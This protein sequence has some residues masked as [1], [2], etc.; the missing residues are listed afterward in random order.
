[1]TDFSRRW[2]LSE[3]RR[4]DQSWG[5]GRKEGPGEEERS[6]FTLL[7]QPGGK[8]RVS[9]RAK[10]LHYGRC[11]PLSPSHLP[12]TVLGDGHPAAGAGGGGGQGA[13]EEG[14]VCGLEGP[15]CEARRAGRGRPATGGPLH[16][17]S[18]PVPCRSPVRNTQVKPHL[19]VP[20]SAVLAVRCAG[21]AVL[22]WAG[23][24]ANV[25]SGPSVPPNLLPGLGTA[26]SKQQ[27]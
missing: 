18:S 16:Q 6:P 5:W 14:P 24:V 20:Q 13:R 23:A 17:A 11:I 12:P 27:R 4:Q 21:T 8:V 3:T 9:D 1:M 2:G 7:G 25:P 19:R 22:R 26:A 15:V 10:Q